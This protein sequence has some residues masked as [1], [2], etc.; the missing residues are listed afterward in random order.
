MWN[1]S[2]DEPAVKT[3]AVAVLDLL[4]YGGLLRAASGQLRHPAGALAVERVRAFH[5]TPK[6][7]SPPTGTKIFKLNDAIVVTRDIDSSLPTGVVRFYEDSLNPLTISGAGAAEFW[8]FVE[9]TR[10]LH[11]EIRTAQRKSG[12]P[13]ARTV[14]VLDE[15]LDDPGDD[16]LNLN[17]AFAAAYLA[18]RA[19]SAAG[20]SKDHLFI[21]W[22]AYY[23]AV[24]MLHTLFP[25]DPDLVT[26]VEILGRPLSFLR[27]KPERAGQPAGQK[28]YVSMNDGPMVTQIYGAK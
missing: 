7:A 20:L 14:V 8:T 27:C 12:Y 2:L 28:T 19:G 17:M 13:G 25:P 3:C 24:G 5:R 22:R 26:G 4:G 1:M 6:L 10:D 9:W 23:A 11:D 16:V 18:D 15:R 21:E